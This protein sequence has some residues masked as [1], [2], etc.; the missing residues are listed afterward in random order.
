MEALHFK[1]TDTFYTLEKHLKKA[2]KSQV[3]NWILQMKN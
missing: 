1:T 2:N 3:S